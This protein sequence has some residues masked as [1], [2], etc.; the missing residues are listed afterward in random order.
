MK[1]R[2]SYLSTPGLAS[3]SDI[4]LVVFVKITCKQG[5]MSL[6]APEVPWN[7]I[8][9]GWAAKVVGDGKGI[10]GRRQPP[11]GYKGTSNPLVVL[12]A[13]PHNVFF[14]KLT[15]WFPISLVSPVSISPVTLS[16]ISRVTKAYKAGWQVLWQLIKQPSLCVCVTDSKR[17]RLQF[18]QAWNIHT[19]A[20]RLATV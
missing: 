10:K 11:R 13:P 8:H 17:I 2:Q 3:G 6:S 15:V 12:F 18:N 4:K 14:V 1:T 19:H 9:K 7:Y 5:G 20:N 16:I